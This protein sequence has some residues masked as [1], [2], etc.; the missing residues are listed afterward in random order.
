MELKNKNGLTEKE[1][2]EI[3][4]PGDYQ[5]PS[6]TVDMLLFTVGDKNGIK[7]AKNHRKLAEKGLKIL[8]IKRKDHPYIG[9]WAIPGGFVEISESIDDAVYRELKEETNIDNVYME[10]LY[11]WG[12]VNRDP[13]MRVMSVSYM[14]LVPQESLKP[15]A[16]DDA[17]EVRWFNVY[18]DKLATDEDGNDYYEFY[19]ESDDEDKI[20]ILYD[21]KESYRNIGKTKIND[22]TFNKATDNEIAFDHY[23]I[24]NSAIDRLRNKVEYTPIA[25]NL[26]PNYFTLTELQ[27]VYEVILGKNL[28]S[29]NF[30]RKMKDFVEEVPFKKEGLA[31]RPS[32]LYKYKE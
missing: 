15:I 4:K 3:Y 9:K 12:D 17:E 10:Q 11:T 25:F 27:Q 16:G 29:A 19:L 28:I 8:L 18:K 30:R 14:A 26:M 22:S 21:L 31:H 23:K 7:I 20:H 6:V 24:I 32:A 2:L 1:F 5:R 13:R